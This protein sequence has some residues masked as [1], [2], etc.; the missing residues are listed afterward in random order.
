MLPFLTVQLGLVVC[1]LP[2][3]FLCQV[4]T[5]TAIRSPWLPRAAPPSFLPLSSRFIPHHDNCLCKRGSWPQP[6]G[7][8][9]PLCRAPCSHSHVCPGL[10]SFQDVPPNARNP[11]L[12]ELGTG[13]FLLLGTAA[14][15]RIPLQCHFTSLAWLGAGAGGGSGCSGSD[16]SLQE[17]LG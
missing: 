5:L 4:P 12:C 6:L 15:R 9:A 3:I 17:V 13:F 11:L 2:Q 7:S 14:S 1:R 16:R 10:C 8:H